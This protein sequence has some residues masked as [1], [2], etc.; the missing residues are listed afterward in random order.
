MVSVDGPL[1]YFYAVLSAARKAQDAPDCAA[2]L[3]RRS[4]HDHPLT[5]ALG[6]MAIT[7]SPPDENPAFTA[8]KVS[9]Q[10]AIERADHSALTDYLKP[11]ET[12]QAIKALNGDDKH[13]LAEIL[14]KDT[15]CLVSYCAFITEA[16][17]YL[18]A[19][20]TSD[21]LMVAKVASLLLEYKKQ[22]KS[23]G[24]FD[25]SLLLNSIFLRSFMLNRASHAP[26]QL[27]TAKTSRRLSTAIHCYYGVTRAGQPTKKVSQSCP[28]C[29]LHQND[30]EAHDRLFHPHGLET[31]GPTPLV[32]SEQLLA[33]V[34]EA[35]LSDDIRARLLPPAQF[36]LFGHQAVDFFS[37]NASALIFPELFLSPQLCQTMDELLDEWI[38]SGVARYVDKIPDSDMRAVVR[39]CY[40]NMKKFTPTLQALARVGCEIKASL[41]RRHVEIPEVAISDWYLIEKSAVRLPYWQI[42]KQT[43][44]Q[45][46][47]GVLASVV[48]RVNQAHPFLAGS[49]YDSGHDF[50]TR[51]AIN[52]VLK[53]AMNTVCAQSGSDLRPGS[54]PGFIG[55]V[56]PKI[57]N[58]RAWDN[59][60]LDSNWSLNFPHG[61]YPHALAITCLACLNGLDRRTLKAIIEHKVWVPIFDSNPYRADIRFDQNDTSR[62]TLNLKAAV[63]DSANSPFKFQKLLTTGELSASLRDIKQVILLHSETRQNALLAQLGKRM[64]MS[65]PLTLGGLTE[66]T[67]HIDVLEKVIATK[68]LNSIRQ[69]VKCTS[70]QAPATGALYNPE[71]RPFYS[72]SNST[73]L[74][75]FRYSLPLTKAKAKRCLAK[76]QRVE[77]V[78]RSEPDKLGVLE[79]STLADIGRCFS[80][81]VY[82]SPLAGSQK[83]ISPDAWHSPPRVSRIAGPSHEDG[84][85]CHSRHRECRKRL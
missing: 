46:I 43:E 36:S 69:I 10:T 67:E 72:G 47:P 34:E 84:D 31:V 79:I 70:S 41:N 22:N 8:I 55:Y 4:H 37:L 51:E 14:Y 54:G 83:A 60:F 2:Q 39:D 64:A 1:H 16:G 12:C 25:S 76:G 62:I 85:S 32:Y 40:S 80:F 24:G 50:F 3:P 29:Q 44:G 35:H 68:H 77:G 27:I 61:K 45:I 63:G 23:E 82:P 49:R 18:A 9:V 15:G 56:P 57:A 53:E 30:R 17:M 66:L 20:P 13:R 42:V 71:E 26:S 58:S 21:Q 81:I 7:T 78:C 59:G 74:G 75:N 33:L 11:A 38:K 28:L 48:A 5:K 19:Q 52:G 73:V 65:E 6:A